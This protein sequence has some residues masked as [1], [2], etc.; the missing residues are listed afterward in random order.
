MPM[1]ELFRTVFAI[2]YGSTLYVPLVL[3]PL[4]GPLYVGIHTGRRA[5]ASPVGG[6]FIGASCAA[7]GFL[8]WVAVIFPFFNIRPDGIL[9][10]IF[11]AAFFAWNILCAFVAGAGGMMGSMLSYTKRIYS[12]YAGTAKKPAPT[13]ERSGDR[14][15]CVPT[16][17]ICPSCG[18]SNEETIAKCKSC[19][20]D[21]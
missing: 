6:F 16:Y 15:K 10:G 4:A 20:R 5:G 7:I 13:A 18:T 21:I 17:I 2:I 14:G 9:S 3:L 1:K 11:I 8:F 12:E 19:G